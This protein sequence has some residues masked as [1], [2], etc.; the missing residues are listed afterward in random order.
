MEAPFA[1]GRDLAAFK[2]C[3][4]SMAGGRRPTYDG[5]VVIVHRELGG[6]IS[7]PVGARLEDDGFVVKRLRPNGILDPGLSLIPAERVAQ[8]LGRVVR[9]V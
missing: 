9:V 6:G 5:D 1:K 7:Q 3:G 4:G 8:V 2:V